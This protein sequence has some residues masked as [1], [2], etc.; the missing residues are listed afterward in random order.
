ML[1]IGQLNDTLRQNQCNLISKVHTWF[2]G[3]SAAN[4]NLL[5]LDWDDVPVV[6]PPI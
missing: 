2:M 1:Q 6:C 4:A 3:T 5:A